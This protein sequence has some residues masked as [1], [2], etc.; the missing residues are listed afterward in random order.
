MTKAFPNVSNAL[1]NSEMLALT[2]PTR[3]NNTP[4]DL[5]VRLFLDITREL[6]DIPVSLLACTWGALTVPSPKVAGLH[7]GTSPYHP[8]S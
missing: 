1:C 5:N 3:Q 7:G 8:H 4:E 2:Y 6:Q